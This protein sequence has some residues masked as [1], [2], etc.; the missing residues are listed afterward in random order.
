MTRV[1]IEARIQL[2]RS[3][4]ENRYKFGVIKM[5]SEGIPIDAEILQTEMFSLIYKL[6]KFE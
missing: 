6:S 2:I 5:A 4:L 1:Q 3:E